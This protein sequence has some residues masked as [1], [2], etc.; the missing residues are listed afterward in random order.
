MSLNQRPLSSA[1]FT[2]SAPPS[3]Y[4]FK[5][6]AS[7][8]IRPSLVAGLQSGLASRVHASQQVCES[9]VEAYPGNS[10]VVFGGNLHLAWRIRC[11]GTPEER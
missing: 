2:P 10:E 8:P 4:T 3:T 7:W 1:F 9:E 11:V 5:L 6:T